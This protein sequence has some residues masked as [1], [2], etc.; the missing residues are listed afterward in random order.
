MLETNFERIDRSFA[1]YLSQLK[2][3]LFTKHKNEALGYETFKKWVDSLIKPFLVEALVE[4]QVSK[5]RLEKFDFFNLKEKSQSSV[6]LLGRI[7][8]PNDLVESY[9]KDVTFESAF[10]SV[11]EVA[12]V[13][14]SK[15]K[16]FYPK[17]VKELL[18]GAIFYALGENGSNALI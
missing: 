11:C 3:G 8:K 16:A 15:G 6:E 10:E 14:L 2:D 7:L 12:G 18:A 5:E 1:A 13:L 17:S 4:A 9:V